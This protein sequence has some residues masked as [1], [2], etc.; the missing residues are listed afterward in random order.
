V[1]DVNYSPASVGDLPAIQSLLADCHLPTEGLERLTEHSIVA[2]SG[3]RLIGTV[4]LE[5]CGR[6]ALLRSLAV[7]QDWR[8]RSLGRSLIAK[9][10][11]YARLLGVQQLYLLTTDA[12]PYFA[13]LGFQSAE[14][15]EAPAQIQAT[16]QFHSLCPKSAVCMV[17]DIASEAI[18]A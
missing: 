6:S 12:E 2:K 14:R 1:K 7:A 11:S 18:H 5:P 3:S 15:G 9:M 16:S 4:T 17:R 8:G 10:V 13:A